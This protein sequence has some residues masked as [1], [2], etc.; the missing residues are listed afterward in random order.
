MAGD[1]REDRTASGAHCIDSYITWYNTQRLQ[2]QFKG[3]TPTEKRHQAL[4]PQPK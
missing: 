3:Q 4:Q 1:V 2:T